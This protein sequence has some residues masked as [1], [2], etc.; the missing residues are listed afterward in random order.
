[1]RRRAELAEQFSRRQ[2][3][4]LRYV[5]S[6]AGTARVIES[7]YERFLDAFEDH[8]RT[9][10]F[11][12]GRRPAA[13]DFGAYGQLTQLAH[14]E[15][16]SSAVALERAPRVFAWVAWV[17]DLSGE[18]PQE[19]DWFARDALPATLL[20]LLREV[21]RVYVPVMLANAAAVRDKAAEVRAEVDGQAWTQQPFSYQ[22][23]CLLWLR[24]EFEA[25][26]AGDREAVC[27]ILEANG[28]GALLGFL[29]KSNA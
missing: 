8:L 9:H 26:Q 7:S 25:L 1:M 13:A 17:D 28:C 24:Q 4:R 18:E 29:G 6:H 27:R 5:G 14:F 3:D 16:T 10:P 21:G 20:A 11:L 2:I 15:P 23:K 19:G 12:L 22:A